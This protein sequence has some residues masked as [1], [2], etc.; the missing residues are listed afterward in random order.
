MPKIIKIKPKKVELKP[1]L[2]VAAYARV[3]T[4][5]KEQQ[6][7]FSAQ[8]SY[9]NDLIQ[10][11]PE[12][13]FSGIYADLGI[14]GTSTRNREEFHRLIADC[15]QGKID[16]VLVKSISRFAR[17]TVDSLSTI[18]KL[19]EKGVEVYFEKENIWTLDAKG[20][21][22]LTIM[23]SFAQEESRSISENTTW[24]KRKQFADGK[25]A[26]AYSRF[27]GYDKDFE[28]NEEE[29]KIIRLIFRLFISGKTFYGVAQEMERRGIPS[30]AGRR[31]WYASTVKSIIT[32]EK[33]KGDALLQKQYTTDFLQKKRKKNEGEIPQY[34]V[35][36]HH[37]PIIPP[38]VFDYVQAEIVRRSKM[39]RYSG[40]DIF[41]NKVR[42]GC[43]GNWYGA[44]VWHSQDKY[45]RVIYRC[46]KKYQK[47]KEPC[48]SPHFSESELKEIFMKALNLLIEE[49]EECIDN[50]KELIEDTCQT[51]EL[52]VQQE[53]LEA[54]I[55]LLGIKTQ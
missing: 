40:A 11:N 7:S 38:P 50:L 48:E 12:W 17:N 51:D 21:M 4:D 45:R 30:P 32:N 49:K 16:L 6:R 14:S 29:A 34:Y 10:R 54:E 52:E 28:I 3:S 55:E 44:K 22:L 8:I 46:N 37:K 35:E 42:C 25:G 39:G 2:R 15:E 43:C 20:E 24:G 47:G 41:A 13:K 18:R 31:K 1:K 33:Y 9:Y 27:L 53:R 36:G 23:S 19:K 26:V 5:E